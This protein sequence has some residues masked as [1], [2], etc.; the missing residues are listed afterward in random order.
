MSTNTARVF[1]VEKSVRFE[2]PPIRDPHILA[3][4]GRLLNRVRHRHDEDPGCERALTLDL[5]LLR[6]C[7]ADLQH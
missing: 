2:C 7:L 1:L 6:Y 4:P 5:V 3:L